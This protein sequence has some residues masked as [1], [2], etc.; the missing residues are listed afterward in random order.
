MRGKSE[1]A[2]RPVNAASA[3]RDA[4]PQAE[5]GDR[6]RARR[7][8][9]NGDRHRARRTSGHGKRMGRGASPRFQR[10]ARRTLRASNWQAAHAPPAL[11]DALREDPRSR[12]GLG[13]GCGGGRQVQINRAGAQLAHTRLRTCTPPASSSP[14]HRLLSSRRIAPSTPRAHRPAIRGPQ[15]TQR[16]FAR[17]KG[18]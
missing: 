9:G 17:W 12:F 1:R 11:R 10:S 5:N 2:P 13:I 4:P 7:P 14:I 18:P 6:H 3:G 8:A 15:P 16:P